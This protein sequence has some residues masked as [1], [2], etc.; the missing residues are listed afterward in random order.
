MN[1]IE[2][3]DIINT[4]ETSRVQFKEKLSSIDSLAGEM[5]AMSN[6]LGGMLI[7]GV[8]DK[9]GEIIGLTYEELQEAGRLASNVA[10]NNVIPL[11]YIE[12]EVVVIEKANDKRNILILHIK[13]GISKP[14]KDKHLVVWTKQGSDKRKVTDNFELLRLFQSSGNLFADE[15]EV[16]NSTI[17]DVDVDKLQ[18]YTQNA[19][20][21]S[22]EETG[23][24]I[25]QILNNIN[26]IRNDRLTL[27]GLLFF[28]VNPQKYKPAF[29]IKAVSF[30]GNAIDG[31]EYRDSKDI[32]G[33]IPELFEKGMEF[34]SCN[35]KHTQQGQRFS[36]LGIM[37]ISKIALE[38]VLQNALVHRDYLKNAP[39][40]AMIFDNRIE[41]VSPGALPNRLTVENIKAGNSVVRNNLLVSYCVKTMPYRGFGSGIKRAIK[42]QP[43]IAFINDI[44]G[45]QFTVTI[46]RP[47]NVS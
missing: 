16:P 45:E 24:K 12:T 43:N 11:I 9:T 28:G 31:T 3:L 21:K 30:F 36:S 6:S 42:E 38:E 8:K 41:I 33:T 5:V 23:L 20:E 10:T 1:A 17:R 22:I 4:G 35:L 18:K 13:E 29:C 46:P 19:L 25:E 37:E 39:I 26:V 2:L 44:D 40:R 14:Y 34:F 7:V 47:E 27:G 15:M 32:A